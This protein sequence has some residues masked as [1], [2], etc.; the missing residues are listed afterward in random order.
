MDRDEYASIIFPLRVDVI[1]LRD[2]QVCRACNIKTT[3][4]I[5]RIDELTKRLTDDFK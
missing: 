2:K 3:Q 4:I 1:R 5:Q